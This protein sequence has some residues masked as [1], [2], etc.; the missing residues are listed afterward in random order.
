MA[1]A[2]S[3]GVRMVGMQKRVPVSAL[4]AI[5]AVNKPQCFAAGASTYIVAIAYP[6]IAILAA[7][8][9]GT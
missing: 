4:S 3:R 1:L 5:S 9:H 7:S 6:K 2:S 8:Q